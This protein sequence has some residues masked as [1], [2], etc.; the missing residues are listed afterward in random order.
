LQEHLPD[1]I[2]LAT[3]FK[4]NEVTMPQIARAGTLQYE[5]F[6][7]EEMQ[8]AEALK[9]TGG[10]KSKA[11]KLLGFDRSTLYRKMKRYKL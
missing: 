10:N 1:E 11:A 3:P 7:S 2:L 4:E 5:T 8:I 9:A 6:K